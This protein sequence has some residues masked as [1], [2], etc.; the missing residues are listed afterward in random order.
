[1][2]LSEQLIDRR[3]RKNG[4]V[5]DRGRLIHVQ[6]ITA[7]QRGP[8]SRRDLARETGASLGAIEKFIS[9]LQDQGAI[10]VS[11]LRNQHGATRPSEIF[12][13]QRVPFECPDVEREL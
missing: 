8:K 4:A 13:M 1:M 11:A 7:L 3:K 12:T 9:V 10:Y 5:V 6:I 2:T